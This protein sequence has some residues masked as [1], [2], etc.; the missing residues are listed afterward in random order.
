ML[1]CLYMKT[2][3]K[4]SAVEIKLTSSEKQELQSWSR[5]RTLP[6]GLSRRAEIILLAAAGFQNLEISEK[7]GLNRLDV[8]KWRRRFSENGIAGLYDQ[9]KPGRPRNVSDDKIAELI[10]TT[11][12]R[13]PKGGTH[14]STRQMASECGVSKSTVQR[15]WNA[16]GIQPHRTK[17]FTLSNDPF[18]VEKVRDI[19]GLYLN[20]PCNALVLCVDEKSQCQALERT[21]PVLPMGL[22]YLEGVTHEYI[23]HGTLTL[24][25]ALDVATG[26]VISQCSA[27]HRHQEFLKFLNRIEAEVPGDLDIHIVMDNYCTHRQKKVQA[28]LAKHPRYHIHFTPTYSSW[29]NQVERWFGLITQRAIR[30]GSFTS[31]RQLKQKI[32]TFVRNHNKNAHPFEWTA[33]ADSIL[34]KLGRLCGNINGTAH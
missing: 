27:R 13:K 8:G 21:Q 26:E 4:S 6:A 19:V 29:L 17:G 12:K 24:F 3:R 5:S 15:V 31:T 16:F 34:N 33:T 20:P 28:W 11:L 7:V 32:D 9:L 30:R 10:N 25:A 22:G 2:K 1:Y 14:W 18:F 23:R